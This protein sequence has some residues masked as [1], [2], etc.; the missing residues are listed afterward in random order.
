MAT[1]L[2]VSFAALVLATFVASRLV[3]GAVRWQ[4][5]N[6]VSTTNKIGNNNKRLFI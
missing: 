1:G 5:Q 2:I 3:S 6:T 4:A